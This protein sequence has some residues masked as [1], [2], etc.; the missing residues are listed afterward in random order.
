MIEIH[1]N[2][3]VEISHLR[4]TSTYGSGMPRHTFFFK[5]PNYQW[6]NFFLFKLSYKNRFKKKT[7]EGEYSFLK[8]P[9]Y[10]YTRLKT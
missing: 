5:R 7:H 3:L 6:A 10:L 8:I 2:R 4:N 9:G 1:S